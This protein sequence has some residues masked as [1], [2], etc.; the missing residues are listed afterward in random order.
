MF[1]PSDMLRQP[2]QTMIVASFG[3]Y[4]AVSGHLVFPSFAVSEESGLPG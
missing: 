4:S 1:A 2:P 3:R